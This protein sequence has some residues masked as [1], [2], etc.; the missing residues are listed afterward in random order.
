MSSKGSGT[1]RDCGSRQKRRLEPAKPGGSCTVRLF[2]DAKPPR[3]RGR[4]GRRG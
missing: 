1:K 3:R 2:E 4:V